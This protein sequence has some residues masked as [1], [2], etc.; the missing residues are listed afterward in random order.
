MNFIFLSILALCV[1]TVADAGI[2]KDVLDESI[3]SISQMVQDVEKTLQNMET[4]KHD[5]SY[6]LSYIKQK[7][8]LKAKTFTNGSFSNN[9]NQ[10]DAYSRTSS[11]SSWS[12]LDDYP[13][14]KL[15]LKRNEIKSK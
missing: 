7:Q 8:E 15:L 2:K 11:L 12:E 14:L 6:L 3:T 13:G 10:K 1:I 4:L 9:Y 5:L